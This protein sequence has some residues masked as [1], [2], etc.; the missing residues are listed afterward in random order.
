MSALRPST[1][2]KIVGLMGPKLTSKIVNALGER[3]LATHTAG[4]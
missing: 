4:L 1:V 3:G 2:D